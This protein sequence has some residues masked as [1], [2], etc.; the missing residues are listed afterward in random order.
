MQED[1]KKFHILSFLDVQD[2]INTHE[3]K[4]NCHM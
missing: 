2:I 4:P 3:E 1:N